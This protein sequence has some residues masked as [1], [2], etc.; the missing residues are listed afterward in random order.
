MP[1]NNSHTYNFAL[2]KYI[3]LQ[4]QHEELSSHLE[5]IRPRKSS[6]TSA[7][8]CSSTNSSDPPSYPRRHSRSGG[9]HTGRAR[10]HYSGWDS[11]AADP[12]HTI[13]DEETL[14]EISS[15]EQR[16]SDINESIKRALTE[17]LNCDAVRSNNTMRMWAQTRLMETEKEL[18]SGRRR[19]SSPCNE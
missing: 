12:L 5:Q 9:R 3:L 11:V 18:R 7:S 8:T 13:L 2:Q 15:E 19:R 10:A 16:L 17:L 1:S 4:E 6:I 14:F